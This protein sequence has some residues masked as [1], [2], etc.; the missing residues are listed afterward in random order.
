MFDRLGCVGRNAGLPTRGANAEYRFCIVN[1]YVLALVEF[2]EVFARSNYA[3]PF[4]DSKNSRSLRRKSCGNCLVQSF[5]DC[6]HG[7]NR[8][9]ANNDAHQG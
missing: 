5:D 7:D 9:D 6:Y 8:S 3:R 1:G 4:G 2:D